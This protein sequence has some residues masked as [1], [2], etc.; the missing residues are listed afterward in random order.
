MASIED[1]LG[2]LERRELLQWITNILILGCI[3]LVNWR[4]K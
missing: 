2:S 4:I 3:F 1:R